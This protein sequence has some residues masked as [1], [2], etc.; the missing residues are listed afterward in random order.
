MY[1]HSGLYLGIFVLEGSSGEC[2]AQDIIK[3]EEGA[4]FFLLQI[5]RLDLEGKKRLRGST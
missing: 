5:T 3:G 1:I 4:E 2:I